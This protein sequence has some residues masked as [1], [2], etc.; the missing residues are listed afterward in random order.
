M[1]E[2]IEYHRRNILAVILLTHLKNTAIVSWQKRLG[3]AKTGQKSH[4]HLNELYVFY[5]VMWM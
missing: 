2:G 1:N 4:I 5:I 3:S